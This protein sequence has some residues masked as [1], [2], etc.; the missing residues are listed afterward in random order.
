MN[1]AGRAFEAAVRLARAKEFV[2]Q[3][4]TSWLAASVVLLS[5]AYLGVRIVAAIVAETSKRGELMKRQK[6]SAAE[7]K[8]FQKH[9]ADAGS[10]QKVADGWGVYTSTLSRIINGHHAPSPLLTEKLKEAKI[11]LA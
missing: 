6:L 5:A 8:R 7:I 10:Q 9:V 2:A 11:I 4:T 1:A 3:A